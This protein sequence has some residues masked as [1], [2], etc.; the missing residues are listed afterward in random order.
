GHYIRDLSDEELAVRMLPFL[1]EAGLSADVSTVRA[2]APHVR[3]RMRTLAEAP[4]LLRF[5]FADEV[6]P[7]EKAAK[8][9]EKAGSDY[10]LEAAARLDAAR[11]WTVEEIQ[12]VLDDLQGSSGRSKRDALQPIRAAITGSTV[13]PPLYE[14]LALLGK[15]RTVARL[16]G[17]AGSSHTT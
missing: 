13:S 10:L 15:E 5:L 6:R 11:D 7:D 4:D 12:R 8:L 2:A 1:A 16:R 9:I 3:E 17:A 14:S